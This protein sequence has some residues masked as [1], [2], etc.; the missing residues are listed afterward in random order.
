MS[1]IREIKEMATDPDISMYRIMLKCMILADLIGYQPLMEWAR[2][3]VEGY[4]TSEL[5]PDYRRIRGSV[6][7]LMQDYAGDEG[8]EL[9]AELHMPREDYEHA[10]T[11]FILQGVKQIILWSQERPVSLPLSYHHEQVLSESVSDGWYLRNC[12]LSLPPSSFDALLSTLRSRVL[13]TLFALSREYPQSEIVDSGLIHAT[14]SV[15]SNIFYTT[16][17]GGSGAT[18]IGG[19]I[20][21]DLNSQIHVATG[22]LTSLTKALR[23]LGVSNEE[24][25]ELKSIMGDAEVDDIDIEDSRL[26]RW[27]GKVTATAISGARIVSRELVLLTVRKYFPDVPP[28]PP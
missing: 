15:V 3:E 4:S 19:T 8:Y 20:S 11:A 17:L 9:N 18:Q 16:L 14:N 28:P 10:S 23:H 25:V 13:Q 22:D 24:L 2:N 6:V 5:L 12:Y 26:R 1:L 21:G 7:A 27:I